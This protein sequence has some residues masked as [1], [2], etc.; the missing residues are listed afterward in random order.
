[1]GEIDPKEDRT[2]SFFYLSRFPP[3]RPRIITAWIYIIGDEAVR[4]TFQIHFDPLTNQCSFF[5]A[6]D[7]PKIGFPGKTDSRRT[8]SRE[9]DFLKTYSLTDN[10]FSRKTYFY[11]VAPPLGTAFV[12]RG[13]LSFQSDFLLFYM[14]PPIARGCLLGVPGEHARAKKENA[15][16]GRGNIFFARVVHQ[17]DEETN[18][19]FRREL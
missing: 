2:Y 3:R 4:P 11:T 1:M 12:H 5:S 10:Q 7:A 9:Y 6:E 15:A 13:I 14:M 18:C 19:I 17:W 16:A 8:F